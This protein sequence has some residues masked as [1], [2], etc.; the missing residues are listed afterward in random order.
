MSADYY[1]KM[2]ESFYYQ[3]YAESKKEIGYHMSGNFETMVGITKEC[4]PLI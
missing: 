4:V 1:Q 3:F 2:G